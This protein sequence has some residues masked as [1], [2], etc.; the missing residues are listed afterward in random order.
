MCLH[1]DTLGLGNQPYIIEL[2]K[3]TYIIGLDDYTNISR[4]YGSSLWLI[5]LVAETKKIGMG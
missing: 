5:L 4:L 1:D 3:G 2:C